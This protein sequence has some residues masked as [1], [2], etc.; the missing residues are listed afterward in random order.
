LIVDDDKNLVET[1]QKFFEIKKFGVD[2]ACTGCEA[3]TKIASRD[4]DVALIDI[5]LPDMKGTELL[6][7][8]RK[9]IP[10][11][12]KIIL[13]GFTNTE[14]AVEAVNNGASFFLAKPIRLDKLLDVVKKQLEERA[15]ELQLCRQL[16]MDIG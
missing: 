16:G 5:C 12:R 2:T 4:Y 13:T 14:N 10:A 7:K 1:F 6:L 15:R 8:F 9:T 11:T 3:A